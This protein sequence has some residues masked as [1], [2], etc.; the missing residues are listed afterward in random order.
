VSRSA[1]SVEESER[2]A[3]LPCKV[4]HKQIDVTKLDDVHALIQHLTTSFG[5]LNGIFH[6][7]GITRDKFLI[8]KNIDDIRDVLAP[9]VQGLFNIDSATAQCELDFFLL[10]SSVSGALGNPGQADY[11]AANGFMDSFA[12]LRYEQV[13]RGERYGLTLSINWPYWKDGGMRIDVSALNSIQKN[14]GVVPLA[15]NIAMRSLWAS[16][17]A[18]EAQVLVLDGNHDLIRQW[19][20]PLTLSHE[21][22][23][24]IDVSNKD[25]LEGEA[26][27]SISMIDLHEKTCIY[28]AKYFSD[29]LHL[30]LDRLDHNDPID[31]YGIDS[32]L[33]LQIIEAIATDLGSLPSTLLFEYPKITLLANAL[34]KSHLEPLQ[35][36]LATNMASLE[37]PIIEDTITTLSPTPIEI[38]KDGIAIISV[39]GQ[40]P[41]ADSVEEFWEML[42]NGGDGITEVPPDRWDHQAIYSEL[43]GKPGATNCKWGG[44]LKNIKCFDP[45]FFGIN[46]RDAALMDPQ[47]RLLLQT[48]WHLLERVGYTRDFLSKHYDSRVGVFVGA[49]YQQYHS[50]DADS[51]SSVMVSLS[52]YASMANRI[53]SF[54]DLQGPSI[55]ID[56]MCSSGLMA[57][58]Q[59]C[60]SLRQGECR[61][62]I[63]GG[64]NLTIHPNKYL[65]LSKAGLLGSHQECLKWRTSR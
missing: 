29:V 2:I 36:I 35:V 65:G 58:H 3:A 64:V 4:I 46:P 23:K 45:E 30:P 8:R 5:R 63:A 12:L 13:S 20:M 33:A 26:S 17:E 56:T 40:Y 41:G 11:A 16:F 28:L 9:K 31:R 24:T 62:A 49:M 15:T 51:E 22:Q 38:S 39:A 50:L 53:S 61:L 42:R 21:I 47:E 27:A 1:L 25:I 52:S 37:E 6:A 32:V 48:S 10:F 54:Y 59:A 14:L 43:K 60:Q 19:M 34:L 18:H 7:A 57:I 44:F 55:A